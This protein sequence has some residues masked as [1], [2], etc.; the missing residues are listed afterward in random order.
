MYMFDIIIPSYNNHLQNV[1]IC[2]K[3]F[4]LNC[5]DKNNVTI[6]IIVS[7]FDTFI[8]QDLI[9]LFPDLCINIINFNMLLKKYNINCDN[10]IHFLENVGKKTYVSFK[11]M[12]TI[13]DMSSEYVCVFNSNTIFIRKFSLKKYID[14][15]SS[16]IYFCS[17]N[18]N[19]HQNF[20][21]PVQSIQNKIMKYLFTS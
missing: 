20:F 9:N 18:I 6:N 10:D 3:S 7:D 11:K 19:P 17:N 14:S 4:C 13:L 12:L 21:S 1:K 2:L 8:F 16:K 5:I 15:Y